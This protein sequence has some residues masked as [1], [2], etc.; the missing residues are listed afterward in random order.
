DDPDRVSGSDGEVNA[1]EDHERT[2]ALAD[3]DGGEDGF[4]R[5]DRS[6]LVGPQLS[7]DW[8][9]RVVGVLADDEVDLE[10][11]GDLAPLPTGD[12]GRDDVERHAGARLRP[13]EHADRRFD[14]HLLHRVGDG[15]LVLRIAALAQR[16]YGDVEE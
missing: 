3:P 8:D 10:L 2:E 4:H 14:L 1:V 9:L 12:G 5:V 16:G 6:L 15:V 11:A 13:V 7:A